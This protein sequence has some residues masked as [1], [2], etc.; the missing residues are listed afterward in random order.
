MHPF[1]LPATLLSLLTT[2]VAQCPPGAPMP[3]D[4]AIETTLPNP[5]AAATR[6]QLAQDALAAG[7][8]AT[9]RQH[10]LAALEFHPAAPALLFDLAIATAK[11]PELGPLWLERYVRAATDA[12]GKLTLDAAAKRRLAAVPGLDAATKASHEIATLRAQALAEVARFAEKHKAGGKGN[13][14][15]AALVRWAAQLA[16]ELGHGAP[17]MLMAHAPAIDRV[18]QAFAC[19]HDLVVQGLQ[20]ILQ[21][22]PPSGAGA[23]SAPTTGAATDA[24]TIADQRIRAARILVGLRRQGTQPDL[25][26]PPAPPIGKAADD[27]DR[28]LDERLEQNLAGK[29][30]SIAEL[31]AM[32]PAEAAAF[33]EQHRD[34]HA[35]GLALSTTS[36][37]RIET[38]CGHGTLLAVA[39]TVELHHA[40]LVDHFGSDPFVQRQGMVRVVP[41]VSDLETEGAPYW[42]AGGFQGGDRTTV[43]FAWGQIPGLGRTIT[44]ELTH[45]FDGVLRPFLGAW[46]G[47]GHAQWTAAHYAKMADAKCV[48]N[49]LDRGTPAHT[50]YK[51]Y[52][53]REK[54]E[55]LLQG[56][57]EDYRDNYFAGYSLYAFLRSY[58]PGAPRYH[59]A[60]ATYEKNA[61]AGQKDPIGFFT[62]TFCDGKQ[63]RPAKLDELF[64]DWQT[65]LRGCYEWLDDKKAGNEWVG[66]YGGLGRGDTGKLVMDPPTWTWA[67]TRAEPFYGQGHAAAAALLLHEVR[68]TEATIA[69]G[70]W[71]LTVDGWRPD[72]AAVLLAALRAGKNSDAALA[73][74][75]VVGTRFADLAVDPTTPLLAQLPRTQAL[76][77]ALATRATT[78]A[79]TA[80]AAATA[81]ADEHRRLALACGVPAAAEVVALPAAAP[82]PVQVPRH[83]GGHGWTESSLT[84]FEDRRVRGLWYATEQ[85]DLHVG[86][87]KPRESTGSLDRHAHQRDAFVHTVGWM[88]PGEYVLRGRVH[89]TTSYVSGAIVFGHTRRDRDL[90]LSFSSGDFDYATGRSERRDDAGNVNCNLSGLWDRDGHM[91]NAR[92]HLTVNLKPEQPW[93]DYVIHVRGPRIRITLNGDSME[94]YCVHDGTPVEGHVGFAMGM[95]A[96]RVQQPTV[97]RLAN[98]APATMLGLDLARQPTDPLSDLLDLPVRGVPRHPD[99]TLVLWLPAVEIG[100][101]AQ[102]LDRM[103]PTLAKPLN[104]ANAHEHPQLWVMAVPATT[105][106][107]HRAEA[108]AML[109]DLRPTPLPVIEHHVLAP[110]D[111]SDP[112]VLFVDGG[113]VLRA[114]ATAGDPHF[115][116][117]VQR[118]SQMYRGRSH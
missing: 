42:W 65:F 20:R 5:G 57:L 49:Y 82:A 98:D 75:A 102:Q 94:T 68:D 118:W 115:H 7:D 53:N 73:F 72:I 70:I 26:G 2:A 48:E 30:W 110:F 61:R 45:R 91:P 77:A 67:R 37:Y 24:A 74:G 6:W 92:P 31:E 13:G 29:I 69:A 35:P 18:Q 90:R 58:P 96:I 76:L 85:G 55:Q 95:G 60:L 63:G 106:A 52:G 108:H 117:R 107:E 27:A 12:Q 89:F 105:K 64:T 34:W 56:K 11:E 50:W 116:T 66:R 17:A 47:E 3:S 104:P 15:R 87:E 101:P 44:H 25:Q 36:R 81:A 33:T 32:T 99:G 23:G 62:T 51:G 114:A 59:S 112:W 79:G 88:A 46:Y 111:G 28:V 84:G 21:K 71:S 100:S 109:R 86:R 40:R 19:D 78:L 4:V 43:H 22:R 54:F 9:A 39:K 16:L 1:R 80:K 8:T 103:L 14:G 10:L 97:Q 38:I 113:G 93:F 41:E 83:L